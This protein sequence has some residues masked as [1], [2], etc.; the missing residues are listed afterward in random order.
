MISAHN[1]KQNGR[2]GFAKNIRSLTDG[3]LD[4]KEVW[5]PLKA[6]EKTSRK[7]VNSNPYIALGIAATIGVTLGCLIKRR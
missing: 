2:E 5:E 3:S 4:P 6:F 1:L 7:W